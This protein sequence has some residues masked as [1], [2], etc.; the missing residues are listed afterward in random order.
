LKN[1]FLQRLI[2]IR[3]QEMKIWEELLMLEMRVL[4]NFLPLNFNQLENFIVPLSYSSIIKD[5][6]A[7]QFNNKQYKI[8]QEGKRNWL[9]I[10]LNAYEIKLQE[11]ER[12]YHNEFLQFE[13]YLLLNNTTTIDGSPILHKIKE[14]MTYQ[15]N[16]LKLDTCNKMS[17]FRIKLLQNRQRSSTAK[18][19]VP[20][21]TDPIVGSYRI[22]CWILS[23]SDD[24]IE[25]YRIPGDRITS[26]SIVYGSHR[27]QHRIL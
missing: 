27:I 12:K 16:R 7:I 24:P 8:I 4:F 2:Y 5:Q 22:L 3:Q 21:S 26:D 6:K 13:K 23:E 19:T 15:T 18:N 10:F 11:Y 9:N 25:S 14:Y 1:D 17:S 20:R